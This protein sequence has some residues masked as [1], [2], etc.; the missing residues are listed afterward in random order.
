V[1][2]QIPSRVREVM[3]ELEEIDRHDRLDGTPR[4][5]RLRQVPPETGRFLALLCASAPDG[6][7][8]EIGTSAGYSALW[9]ALACRARGRQ[10]TTYEILPAKARRA[11]ATFE[12]AG[13]RDVVGLVEGDVLE[14]VNSLGDVGFCF[15]D[16]EKDVYGVCVDAVVANLVPGGILVADN[17]ISHRDELAS[18]VDAVLGDPRVDAVVVPLGRGELVAR[19]V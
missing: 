12:R 11:R 13:V 10:L 3:D 15:L 7:V 16:A 8:I 4:L 1:F 5:E 9:L 19:R 14:H 2:H 18:V 17:V 6:G